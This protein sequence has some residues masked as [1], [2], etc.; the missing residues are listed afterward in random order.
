MKRGEVTAIQIH[1]ETEVHAK[2]PPEDLFVIAQKD[3]E[4]STV[5]PGSTS[6]ACH[7]HVW[8]KKPALQ[9]SM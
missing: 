1:A 9:G 8:R 4:D 2:K 6:I 3:L 5:T 7:T